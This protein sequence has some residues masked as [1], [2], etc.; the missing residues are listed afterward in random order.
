MLFY[1]NLVFIINGF[2]LKKH[3]SKWVQWDTQYLVLVF[4]SNGIREICWQK[5]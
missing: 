4:G 2:K 5:C 3:F 1:L